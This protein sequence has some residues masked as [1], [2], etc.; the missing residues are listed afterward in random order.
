M[1]PLDRCM[2]WVEQRHRKNGQDG[3]D[4]RQNGTSIRSSDRSDNPSMND[5]TIKIDPCV[6][7]EHKNTMECGQ[8]LWLTD[9][10]KYGV[11]CT[12]CY[13][14]GPVRDTERQAIAAYNLVAQNI[15]EAK[16]L[17]IKQAA[18]IAR[19]K[20]ELAAKTPPPA[21]APYH[22]LNLAETRP[23]AVCWKDMY[24]RYLL[25]DGTI[26]DLCRACAE[27]CGAILA[28]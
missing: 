28:D 16:Q 10:Y 5:E 22:R 1:Q 7:C 8:Y 17:I 9:I 25:P 11:H 26:K 18:E 12:N 21:I 13:A 24:D 27:E 15:T 14:A 2:G 19:L 3:N 4:R 6:F 20:N 23:C